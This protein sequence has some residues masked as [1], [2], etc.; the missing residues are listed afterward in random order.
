[1]AYHLLLSKNKTNLTWKEYRS[2]LYYIPEHIN[3]RLH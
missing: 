3:Y 1:M 2:L